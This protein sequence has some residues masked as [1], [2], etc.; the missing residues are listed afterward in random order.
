MK[1]LL[2]AFAILLIGASVPAQTKFIPASNEAFRYVGRFDFSNPNEVRF[3]WSGVGRPP[4]SNF[5][6]LIRIG[7]I[8]L[9]EFLLRSP[10]E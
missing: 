8:F 6:K 3:D 2:L 10:Y 1:T 7:T 4:I 5:L 9:E